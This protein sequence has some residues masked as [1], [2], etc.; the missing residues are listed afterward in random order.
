[1]ERIYKEWGRGYNV[2]GSALISPTGMVING[3][4]RL[5]EIRAFR[6]TFYNPRVVDDLSQTIAPPYDVIDEKKKA[7]L[8]SRSPYNIV[9]LILPRARGEREFWNN[10]ATLFRAWKRGEVLTADGAS[11]YYIYRQT[12][13]LPGEEAVSRTGILALLRCKDFSSGDILPHEKTFPRTMEERLNLLRACR[14]NFSQIFTVL[15][16]E[17]EDILALLEEAAAAPAF[18]ELR[19]GEG[20][21]H[22]V[23]RL[24]E[25]DDT[26][27]LAHLVDGKKLIIADGHHRY[28]TALNFSRE[29]HASASEAQ[30]AAYV[31]AV[32]FRSEDP[33][34]SVLP[35]HRVLGNLPMSTRE[36]YRR[37][38]RH[39]HVEVLRSDP[40]CR[41]GMYQ[42]L[43]ASNRRPSFIM[44]TAEGVATLV[45]RDG[46]KPDK[47]IPGPESASWKRLDISILHS[48]VISEGLGLDASALGESGELQY[49]PWESAAVSAVAAG[50]AEAAFLVRPTLMREIWEIA[51]GGERMPH[52]SSYFY[53]KLASGLLIYDHETALS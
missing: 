30:A 20:V 25:E 49:T 46:V 18:M 13:S 32:I 12:F 14:A 34:L 1:M 2:S 48:L 19:D 37:L 3:R 44:I 50:E 23:W 5:A 11:C 27:R 28:E 42:E 53:P 52:K 22:Q 40:G 29:R 51:E 24:R 21:L 43:M 47:I 33:G 15:R 39:F 8:A 16:D 7:V 10:S 17:E 6:G 41:A 26:G 9:R 35:V 36:A 38:E 4:K 45:L 31:S